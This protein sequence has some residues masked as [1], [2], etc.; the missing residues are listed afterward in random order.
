M[1]DMEM[2]EDFIAEGGAMEEMMGDEMMEAPHE[3]F[4]APVE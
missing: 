4:Y 2:K 1:A 3:S